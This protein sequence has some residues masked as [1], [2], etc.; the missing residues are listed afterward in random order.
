[1][2]LVKIKDI[3]DAGLSLYGASAKKELCESIEKLMPPEALEN[4]R[5][6][7]IAI[8]EGNAYF[9]G[10]CINRSL[11]GEKINIILSVNIP[12]AEQDF[13]NILVSIVDISH[14]KQAEKERNELQEKN[15]KI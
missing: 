11:T 1:M 8:A 10:E 15:S 6:L 4:F 3:N 5:N 13:E 7:L 9:E 14:H 2:T 12:S